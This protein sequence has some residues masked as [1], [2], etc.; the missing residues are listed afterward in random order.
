V[1][2]VDVVAL[3]RLVLDELDDSLFVLLFGIFNSALDVRMGRDEPQR[4]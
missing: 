2:L 4:D 3:D 1:A